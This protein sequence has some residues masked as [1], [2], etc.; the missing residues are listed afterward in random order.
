MTHELEI[1]TIADTCMLVILKR[2]RLSTV[3]RVDED[4]IDEVR[5]LYGDE[6]LSMSKHLF[7]EGPVRM[8]LRELDRA[9]AAHKDMSAAYIDR[10][11]RI[12]PATKFE[13]YAT[14]MEEFR[15]NIEKQATEVVNDWDTHVH[16]DMMYRQSRASTAQ[17]ASLISV[18]EYPSAWQAAGMFGITWTVRPIAKDSDFRVQVPQ[19]AKDNLRS[20]LDELVDIVRKD[21][22]KN[23]LEPVQEA[24]KKLSIPIGEKGS[25]FRDSLVENLR[26][27]LYKAREMNVNQDPALTKA[28]EEMNVVV[29]GFVGSPESMRNME[30][31]RAKAAKKLDELVGTF[32]DL[33]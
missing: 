18:D 4:A 8:L 21:M 31:K 3:K 23:M 12:I 26:Q 29:N 25:V 1:P 16:N 11:P 30:E 32:T 7:K 33:M 20:E 24:V 27:A 14:T 15:M 5:D 17:R 6:S 13:E 2:K 22:L 9:Y 19:Y 28:I 10:G